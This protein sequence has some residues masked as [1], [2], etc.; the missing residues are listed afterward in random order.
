MPVQYIIVETANGN[1]FELKMVDGRVLSSLGSTDLK[2]N[3]VKN[4]RN[5]QGLGITVKD[6]ARQTQGAESIYWLY[7][8]II[9]HSKNA[10]QNGKHHASDAEA[11]DKHGPTEELAAKLKK[12]NDKI[13]MAETEPVDSSPPPA[14]EGAPEELPAK[15][16]VTEELA[17]KLNKM[18]DRI[19]MAEQS[20]QANGP[21]LHPASEEASE[22]P[23]SK[24]EVT[25]ELA[26]KLNK[27]NEK[28][29]QA[30]QAA[31]EDEDKPPAGKAEDDENEAEEAPPD[32][33]KV[34]DED[35]DDDDE[36]EKEGEKAEEAE[37]KNEDEND[38]ED[39]V[40]AETAEGPPAEETPQDEDEQEEEEAGDDDGADN[41]SPTEKAEKK[42]NE[43]EE[44]E[45]KEENKE[46]E[47]PGKQVTAA[48][49]MQ[50]KMAAR[51]D[52]VDA[53]ASAASAPEDKEVAAEEAAVEA[54]PAEQTSA[55]DVEQPE[56][57]VMADPWLR[58]LKPDRDPA[59]IQELL[60]FFKSAPVMV[61][62]DVSADASDDTA[63]LI[64][65]VAD[66][67]CTADDGSLV[68][69]STGSGHYLHLPLNGEGLKDVV[70]WSEYFGVSSDSVVAV[71]ALGADC[72]G[73]GKSGVPGLEVIALVEAD[74]GGLELLCGAV[75][76]DKDFFS[77]GD[78]SPAH[79]EGMAFCRVGKYESLEALREAAPDFVE[80][81]CE[82]S[83][84]ASEV[85]GR[86]HII[87]KHMDPPRLSASP[88][89][90]QCQKKA[91]DAFLPA[92]MASSGAQGPRMSSS[93]GWPTWAEA[94]VNVLHEDVDWEEETVCE[95]LCEDF[96][97]YCEEYELSY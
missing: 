41:A 78:C 52:L 20:E 28:I 86:A 43:D 60:D 38:G 93:F 46:A 12:M 6:V 17:A 56:E 39:D 58:V 44:D 69:K 80:R 94:I 9:T 68:Q 32:D 73:S 31:K 72:S 57:V 47:P 95:A 25:E 3:K 91:M 14:S 42:D 34:E 63:G 11:K 24:T 54:S 4:S 48:E 2:R 81:A 96:D 23:A 64:T 19:L 85:W 65:V 29:M 26:A 55:A 88:N 10:T 71:L 74:A 79:A 16:E 51:R 13:L 27:M 70:P 21:S 22:E 76:I 50:I 15:T 7:D 37:A 61:V 62:E 33:Q 66:V 8:K 67:Q 75:F 97:E 77:S 87:L 84:I 35:G 30:E 82:D 1:R 89:L 45:K 92:D 49:A 5:C 18:N 40:P 59:L 53:S 90:L 36:E 83:D